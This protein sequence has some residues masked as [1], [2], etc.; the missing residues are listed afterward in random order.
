MLFVGQRFQCLD[1]LGEE[2][3]PQSLRT[4]DHCGGNEA[5]LTWHVVN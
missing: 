2:A 4:A 5:G 3:L 1:G